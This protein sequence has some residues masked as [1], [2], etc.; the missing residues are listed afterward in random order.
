VREQRRYPPDG[1]LPRLGRVLQLRRP[2]I[3]AAAN[4]N[5][6][7]RRGRAFAVAVAITALLAVAIMGLRLAS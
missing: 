7:A 3:P 6:G 2:V 5:A 4:D 1:T